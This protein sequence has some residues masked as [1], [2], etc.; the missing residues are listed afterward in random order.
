MRIA[1]IALGALV[2]AS[3]A[4][5]AQAYD[6]AGTH[7]L[8]ARTALYPPDPCQRH[9]TRR[10]RS[11]CRLHSGKGHRH[12]IVEHRNGGDPSTSLKAP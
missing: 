11:R 2:A 5:P 6:S 1:L 10:A 12:E 7:K 9:P 4:L 3:G 8:T